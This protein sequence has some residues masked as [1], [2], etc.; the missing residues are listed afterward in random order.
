MRRKQ[1]LLT[2]TATTRATS[3]LLSHSRFTPCSAQTLSPQKSAEAAFP[4]RQRI[5]SIGSHNGDV[6][7]V[8][9]LKGERIIRLPSYVMEED[10]AAGRPVRLM[11]RGNIGNAGRRRLLRATQVRMVGSFG[12]ITFRNG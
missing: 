4:N 8:P 10:I 3:T 1:H 12:P 5:L 11:P 6:L 2:A 7:R 9:A